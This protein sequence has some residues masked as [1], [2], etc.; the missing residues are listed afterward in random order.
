MAD[1]TEGKGPRTLA[2]KLNHLY[3]CTRPAGRKPY[4][5][6]HVAA[7]ITAAGTDVSAT[8]LNLLRSGRKDNP[9]KRHL[10][11]LAAFFGVPVSYFFDDEAANEVDQELQRLSQLRALKEA[12][13]SPEVAA[14]VVKARGLST[15]SLLQVGAIIDH[16]RSLEQDNASTR[17][18]KSPPTGQPA[19]PTHETGETPTV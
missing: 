16:V 3:A 4:T 18:G 17:G 11:A 5:D 19:A 2:E 15:G 1:E 8:Y 7:A 6:R 10:E 12:L 13:D 9:T 14:I